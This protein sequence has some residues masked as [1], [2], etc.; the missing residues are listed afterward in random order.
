MDALPSMNS[1]RTSLWFSLRVCTDTSSKNACRAA[2]V[3]P[4]V[5]A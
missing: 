1:A 4:L 3:L 2:E 5:G